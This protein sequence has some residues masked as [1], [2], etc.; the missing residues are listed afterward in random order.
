M[1]TLTVEKVVE[2]TARAKKR[3]AGKEGTALRKAQ[4]T[5]RRL[6]RKR[7]R[8]EVEVKRRAGKAEAKPEA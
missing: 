1:P 7:R 6:Q 3:V 8:L 4:K 2:K 5:V